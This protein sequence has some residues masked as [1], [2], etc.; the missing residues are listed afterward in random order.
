MKL[1][2]KCG[3]QYPDDANFCPI[4]A[5]RLPPS[6]IV[7][8][9]VADAVPAAAAARADRAEAAPAEERTPDGKRLLG[10]RF[11]LGARIGGRQTGEVFE[12]VDQGNG[13]A[14][15]VKVLDAEVFPSPL[16]M[17]RTERELGKLARIDASGIARILDHGRLD[18]RLWI[19]SERV[20]ECRSLLDIVFDEGP[21][22]PQRA[23]AIVLEVGKA[24]AE[25]AKV[26]IIHRDLAPKNVLLG[27]GGVLKLINFGVAVPATDKVQGVPEFV[28]PEIVEGK[29]VDQRANIYSL[30]ALFYYLV[31]GR[32]PYM[33][34]PEE[35]YE[36]HLNA[37]PEP[38]SAHLDGLSEAVDAVILRALARSS[39]RRFMTL[40]QLLTDVERIASGEEPAT[41][42]SAVGAI[43][44][45]RGKNKSKKL[46]QTMLGG[47][48]VAQDGSRARQGDGADEIGA[49]TQADTTGAAQASE[50][51]GNAAQAGELPAVMVSSQADQVDQVDQASPESRED[52][53]REARAEA[54]PAPAERAAMAAEATL[55][56]SAAEAPR[57]DQASEPA[58]ATEP[59]TGA[60]QPAAGFRET[61]WFKEGAAEASTRAPTAEAAVKDDRARYSLE[62]GATEVMASVRAPKA[63]SDDVSSRELVKEMKAGRGKIVAAIVL[64]LVLVAL[65]IVFVVAR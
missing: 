4:D 52:E 8:E 61:K 63:A 26:G 7:K 20:P 47:F 19:A 16:V 58:A 43:L 23:A 31:A 65:L 64:V 40:R 17:Q 39:S 11:V 51:R 10:G 25:A 22:P 34:E 41:A 13:Q 49:S 53:Q 2:P 50:P 28:A 45:A 35:V 27:A 33:G 55:A 24:L 30:G 12:A 36:Q 18:S 3:T 29:P 14:C 38:P 32:P 59:V 21:M 54:E 44:P 48:Q 60:G 46:A 57:T 6:T 62:T 5:A 15:V 56:A 42:P 37:E 9:P 1:C